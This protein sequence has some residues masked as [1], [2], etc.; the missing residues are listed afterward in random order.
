MTHRLQWLSRFLVDFL[1]E[2]IGLMTA[3]PAESA[4]SD[5]PYVEGSET[6]GD[7]NFRTRQMDCGTDPAGWY[8]D[9]L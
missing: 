5:R 4:E 2:S 6:F 1:R 7:F 8:E 9:E 3:A